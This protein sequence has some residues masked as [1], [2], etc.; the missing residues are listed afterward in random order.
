[1]KILQV[2]PYFPPAYAFGG[3]V[4]VVY[5]ISRGLV[6]R[7]HEVVVYTTDAKDFG[8]R[9]VISSDNI[10][11]GVKVHRFRNV[12]LTLVKKFKLFITPQ[13]VSLVKMEIKKFNVIH[14][15][16][17][18]TFQNIVVHHY[19]RKYGLPYVLQAHGS[20][21]R[22]G[23]WPGLKWLFDVFFGYRVL[24]DASKVIALSRVEAEQYSGMGLPEEKIEV[25]PNGIDL[26]EYAD[27][28]PKGCFKKKFGIDENDKIVLYLGRIHR[29]KGID[30]LVKAFTDVIKKLDNVRLVVVGPDD[31]YL[32]EIEALI[33]NLKIENDVLITGPLYGRDK[34]EA[35][36]DADIYV[37]PSRYE[38]FGMTILEV[39]AC[40][41]PIVATDVSGAAPNIVLNGQT[42][43][44]VR[45]NSVLELTESLEYL[46]NNDD[47]S[48][49]MGEQARERVVKLFSIQNTVAK[50]ENLYS[51]ICAKA[52]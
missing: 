48:K 16:E 17:Y 42:G 11:D 13:L 25:I 37:L 47:K 34:I 6:K 23:A 35:Y 18:R 9:M 33:R 4:K 38:I 26:S 32:S 44:L 5:Q 31:G 46:L 10:V 43:F 8:S 14:L 39:A 30:I 3:P 41:R 15:H 19:A 40:A 28:P 29:I 49:K 24:R 36:V 45:P 22:I 12:S 27:L 52:D 1:M 20:F 50:I 51:E 7:G 21:P 2:V